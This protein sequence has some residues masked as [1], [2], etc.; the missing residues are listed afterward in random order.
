MVSPFNSLGR[1]LAKKIFWV[2]SKASLIDRSKHPADRL[3]KWRR[4]NIKSVLCYFCRDKKSKF[5]FENGE[6]SLR[7]EFDVVK[8]VRLMKQVK[9]MMLVIFTRRERTLL[10]YNRHMLLRPEK[11]SSD[12]SDPFEELQVVKATNIETSQF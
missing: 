11:E 9:A 5:I 1:S 2:D 3:M 6:N 8:F 4:P 7:Q 12:E 10:R